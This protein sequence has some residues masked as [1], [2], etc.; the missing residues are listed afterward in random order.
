MPHGSR[1][2]ALGAV[3]ALAGAT[4]AACAPG[5]S[6]EQGTGGTAISGAAGGANSVDAAADLQR[7][8]ETLG[9]LAVDDGREA[10]W[11]G[12]FT[13]AT[14]VTSVTPL[15]RLLS[16]QSNCFV[17][18]A[19]GDER[20]SERFQAI[21]DRTRS[22]EFRAGSNYQKG[23]AVAADYFL[24]PS[25]LYASQD[26][27]GLG[28]AVG[29]L[30]G[31]IGAAVGAA[32][33]NSKSTSVTLSLFSLREEVQIVAAEGSATSTDL[34]AAFGALG[35]GAGGVLGGY[36]KTPAGKATAAAFLDAFNQMV[37]ATKNYRA[38]EVQG[39]LGR[40]GRMK[41]SPQ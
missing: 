26:S 33:M 35:L 3:L 8:T 41:V 20:L 36:S 2:R 17:V 34:G 1:T 38:Q 21:K 40:G 24:E 14:G 27:G 22:G 28:G 11:Y 13:N 16:Q 7:C 9:T 12:D 23:Q 5:G 25:I 32:A 6:V 10:N 18:T 30:L 37:V 31:S 19:V 15:I 4:L 39:G 29:G